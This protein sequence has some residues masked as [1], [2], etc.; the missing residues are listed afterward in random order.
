MWVVNLAHGSLFLLG[1]YVALT[2]WRITGS[3]WIALI[4]SPI[5]IGLVGILIERIWL[6]RFYSRGHMDQVILTLGFSLVFTDVFK[7]FWGVDI[8]ALSP[9]PVLQG[10]IHIIR[11]QFPSYRLFVI[12]VGVGLCVITWLFIERTKIGALIRAAVSDRDM[13]SGLGFNVGA[14]FSSMFAFGTFLAGLGGVF[15]APILGIYLGLDS[16][17]LI[18]T[19]IVIV[20][21]GLGSITGAF[22]ASILIG[23]LE[24]Y[25]RALFP[26]FAMFLTFALMA[27]VLLARSRGKLEEDVR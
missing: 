9:P 3:F 1:A 4:I 2:I 22:W 26:Q 25:G 12:L 8:H 18:T 19:F 13:V 16:E 15:A 21:G 24:T 7:F 10:V 20:V 14:I 11:S 5:A 23:I 27:I 6:K 17:I